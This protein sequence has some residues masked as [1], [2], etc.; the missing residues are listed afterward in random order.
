MAQAQVKP[1]IKASRLIE[2]TPEEIAQHLKSLRDDKRLTLII[3][4]DELTSSAHTGTA[5]N[6]D[7][8][9]G[10][11]FRQILAPATGGCDSLQMSDD[12]LSE[13]IES[14]VKAYRA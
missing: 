5:P 7:A 10:M 9:E 13:L 4:G 3:P 1:R 12:E 6:S 8:D 2:G 11:T 14:E